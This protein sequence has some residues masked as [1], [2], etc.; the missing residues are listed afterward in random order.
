MSRLELPEPMKVAAAIIYTPDFYIL[1]ERVKGVDNGE[2][3]KVGLPGGQ[4][5][6]SKGD[7]TFSDTV[8]R[9]IEEE[10]GAHLKAELF[11]P[12][13]IIYVASERDG[14]TIPVEAHIFSLY[15]DFGFKAE[16][17]ENSVPMTEREIKIARIM[18]LLTSVASESFA[19]I[20]G[21]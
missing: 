15:R 2:T 6:A 19:K 3:D 7:R 5:N 4:F 21:I 9:E 17:L 13:E 12:E 10:T 11:H 1:H 14:K 20:K 18:G 16:L 8:S